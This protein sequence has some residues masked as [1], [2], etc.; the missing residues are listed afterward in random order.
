MTVQASPITQPAIMV[1]IA[2]CPS[3]S[4][5]GFAAGCPHMRIARQED[6]GE[7]QLGC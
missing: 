5:R 3:V 2:P 7:R 6:D 4:G 1:H